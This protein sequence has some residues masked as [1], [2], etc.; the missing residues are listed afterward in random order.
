MEESLTHFFK[1]V[2][3]WNR[4]NASKN[5]YDPLEDE[6]VN[7]GI[8]RKSSDAGSVSRTGG[9]DTTSP[10]EYAIE[11]LEARENDV[12]WA[13]EAWRK[14]ETARRIAANSRRRWKNSRYLLN[15]VLTKAWFAEMGLPS[16]QWPN[17]SNRPVRTRMPVGVA[18]EQSQDCPLCRLC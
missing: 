8:F 7:Q 2:N 12:P 13:V 5:G 6:P 10:A 9:M 16:L 11:T 1:W 15:S 3:I 17:F 18:G 14:E 4:A